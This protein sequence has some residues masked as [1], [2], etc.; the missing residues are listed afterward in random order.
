MSD[1]QATN[2]LTTRINELFVLQV[3]VNSIKLM[4]NDKRLKDKINRADENL[5]ENINFN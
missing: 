4:I 2:Q 5:K 1:E 3:S